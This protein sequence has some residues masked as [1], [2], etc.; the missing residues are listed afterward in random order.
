MEQLIDFTNFAITELQHLK[1]TQFAFENLTSERRIVCNSLPMPGEEGYI[2][3]HADYKHLFDYLETKK[4]HPALYYFYIAAGPDADKILDLMKGYN[5]STDIEKRWSLPKLN[6]TIRDDQSRV[7]Y[8]GKSV[9]GLKGRLV[10][11]L[12]YY[13]KKRTGGLH[14]SRWAPG[15]NIELEL[16]VLFFEKGMEAFLAPF[17]NR[18]AKMM[19]P[20]AGQHRL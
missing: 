11:H 16:N 9:K 6:K 2:F 12:G 5:A 8:V 20:I 19:K 3:E 18:L 4:R 13:D 10:H 14:L 15:H 17:E 7:L 1:Q